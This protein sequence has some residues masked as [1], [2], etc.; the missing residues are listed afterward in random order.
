VRF[1]GFY[2]QELKLQQH[3]RPDVTYPLYLCPENS[4]YPIIIL[5]LWLKQLVKTSTS[6]QEVW[7][8]DPSA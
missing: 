2:E 7:V 8:I 3:F 4:I 5:H 1:A 6:F